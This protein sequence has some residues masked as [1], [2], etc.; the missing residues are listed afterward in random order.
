MSVRTVTRRFR[1][2]T[3]SSAGAWLATQRVRHAQRLL[4]TTDLPI[5][6]VAARA[7]LGTSASLRQHL[8]RVADVSPSAYRRTFRASGAGS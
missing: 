1:A 8:R 7:G 3:G 2:E 6:E 4:E 5:D